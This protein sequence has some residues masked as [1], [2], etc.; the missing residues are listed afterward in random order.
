MYW[1][2]FTGFLLSYF[3][4]SN[5]F[6]YFK[7]WMNSTSTHTLSRVL[8]FAGKIQC[9]S[10]INST[11]CLCVCFCILKQNRWFLWCVCSV[12][13]AKINIRQFAPIYIS[14]T[15]RKK[16]KAICVW[17]NSMIHA[18]KNFDN[19]K[20]CKERLTLGLT[21]KRNHISPLTVGTFSLRCS[22]ERLNREI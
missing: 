6:S 21:T 22:W 17:S 9:E 18:S 12:E 14:K 3:V 2:E 7:L 5:I 4:S 16:T 13:I 19:K 11:L 15:K 20:K 10:K 1:N 8:F